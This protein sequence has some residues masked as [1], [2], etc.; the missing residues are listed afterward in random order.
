VN[1][2]FDYRPALRAR[3][4]VGEYQHQLLSALI[5]S[6]GPDDRL[7]LFTSSWK[8]RLVL[9]SDLESGVIRAHDLRVP[10]RV[11]NLLWH[12]CEWPPIEML[13]QGR[14]DVVHAAHPLL[15][16]TRYAAQIATVHDLDVLDHPEWSTAE[17]RRDYPRLLARHLHRAHGIVTSSNHTRDNVVARL[18]VSP[19][20]LVV[21]RPGLPAWTLGGRLTPRPHD[22]YVLFVGTLEPRKNLGALL[23][24]YAL[25]Q[26]R[27]PDAPPLKVAG[28]A[29][30]AAREWLGRASTPSLARRVEFLGYVPDA[31]RRPLLEG[32]SVL[33]MPSW[34]EGFGLPVLEAM[35]LG[36]PVIASNRG[37]LPELI[38]SDG[39]L[40]EPD[41]PHTIADALEHVLDDP[42]AADE[43]ARHAFSR[44]RTWSW[45]NA[46]GNV[47]RLYAQAQER[48]SR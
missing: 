41:A 9:S 39:L 2:L 21:A 32:A 22:G 14:F 24:A 45:D 25:F 3:S 19:D 42:G 26:T 5:R 15:I 30:P 6:A 7:H 40:V 44:V 43:R 46:A 4:G 8:D 27:R 20:K 36:V 16:P 34:H 1:L 48:R 12:R 18:G 35:A 37:A 29:T 33:V 23:E 47:R 28:R 11:L 10:V 17:I 31:E 38:G 13:A